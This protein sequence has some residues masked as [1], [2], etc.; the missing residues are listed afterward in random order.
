M[1]RGWRCHA[2]LAV[3][4]L[5]LLAAA[6]GGSSATAAA[7]P[8]PS[9]VIAS[10]SAAPT[11]SPTPSPPGFTY[12]ISGY[13]GRTAASGTIHI[14]TSGGTL[15]LEVKISGLQGGSSH[16]SHVH[17]GS[18]AAPGSIL[19]ALLQVVADSQGNADATTTVDQA[20]P[21]SATTWY[22]VVHQ[23]PDMQGDNANYLM[24]GNL[25]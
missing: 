4:V 19:F 9:P 22:V 20:F 6:C 1:R 12:P 25:K 10:P 24:C 2:A 23:G 16:V 11:P 7:S 18:C 15:I 21:P 8:T 14:T 5:G 13:Q 3:A 17:S